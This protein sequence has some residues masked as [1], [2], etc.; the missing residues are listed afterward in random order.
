[1]L[2]AVG[3]FLIKSGAPEIRNTLENAAYVSD[4]KVLPENEG[5]IVIV[6]GTLDPH[7]PF[8]DKDTGITVNSIVAWRHVQ[9]LRVG[10]DKE[11]KTKYWVWEYEYSP[12]AFGGDKKLVSPNVTLGEFSVAEGFIKT[13][14]ANRKRTEYTEKELNQMGWK[15]HMDG[16]TYYLYQ[17]DSMPKAEEDVERYNLPRDSYAY[18]EYVDTLRVS[19]EEREGE[20]DY[21]IVGLQQNGQLVE[22]PE[23]GLQFVCAGHLS[24]E[25]LVELA[26]SNSK[27]SSLMS[28]GFAV[29][30]LAAGIFVLVKKEKQAA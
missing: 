25:A 20:L 7:L 10:E 17:G 15:V 16:S 27:S 23:L 2:S 8:V 26:D 29:A 3:G 22:A 5:K 4:G 19:Y 30:L 12:S 6:P 24:P 9:K 14:S 18:K 21:T 11:E 13:L 1:M 28:F